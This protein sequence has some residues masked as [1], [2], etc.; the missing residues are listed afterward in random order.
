MSKKAD[1]VNPMHNTSLESIDDRRIIIRRSFAAP[2]ELVFRAW[3]DPQLIPRWWAPKSQ[4]LA[5]VECIAD[6]AV[7]G[8]FRYVLQDGA[9]QKYA[10]SGCYQE[11]VPCKSLRYTQRFEQPSD[12]RSVEITVTFEQTQGCT[13]VESLEVY[14][15]KESLQ[16]AISY[17]MEDGMRSSMDQLAEL[18]EA[19]P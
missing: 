2:V 11:I 18:V 4:G 17:G 19:Q 15:D 16:T 13:R 10:F 7:G 14:P 1:G 9:G 5:M 8:S 6:L 12:L 3:T